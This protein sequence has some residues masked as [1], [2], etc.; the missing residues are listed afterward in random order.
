MRG[1]KKK[2][3]ESFYIK[4]SLNNFKRKLFESYYIMKKLLRIFCVAM[5]AWFGTAVAS[6]AVTPEQARSVAGAFLHSRGGVSAESLRLDKMAGTDANPYYY[7][8][9]STSGDGFVIVSAREPENPVLGY[10]LTGNFPVENVP[11]VLTPVLRSM[12]SSA[13]AADT[14]GQEMSVRRRQAARRAVGRSAGKLLTTAAWSQEAPFNN[15]IPSRRLVGCVGTAMATI[16]KYHSW[17]AKGSGSYDGVDFSTAYN[18]TAMRSDNYRNGYSQA[19]GEAVA[20]LMWHAAKSIGTQFGN[21]GSSAYEVRVPLAL[22]NYFGYDPGVSYKKRSEVK[23][24]EDWVALICN[25]IDENRP[26]LYCGQDMTVGHAFVCDG[27]DAQGYL[28]INWGWGG[29]ANG[30]FRHDDLT[31]TVSTTHNFGN[32]NTIIYN[33]KPGASKSFSKI[34]ITSDGN[35]PGIGSDLT[36]LASGDV[37]TVRVGNL[38]NLDYQDFKGRIAVA[39]FAADGTFKSLLS[40]VSNL[41]LPSMGNLFNGYVN[42]SNCALPSAV[43]VADG[44][45]V[46]IVT[47]V[48]SAS[49]WEPVAGELNTVN[50]LPASRAVADSFSITFPATVEGVSI[51]GAN[52]V[53][54][55]WDYTFRA[56][57]ANPAEDVVSVKANGIALTA[58]NNNTYRIANVCEPQVITLL[59]QK[60]SEVKDKRSYWVDEPGTLAAVIPEEVAATV[61]ELTLFGY[62]DSRDF[63]FIRTAMKL[64]RLDISGVK[65]MAYGTNQTNAVPREA[66]RGC[67]QLKEVILPTSVNRLNNGCFRQ[68]GITTITIPSGVKTYEYN[69][70]CGAS[71]LRDVWVGRESAEFINWCV[72]SGAKTALMTLHV[73]TQ[74]AVSNY[75]AAENWQA[76]ANIIVDPVPAVTEYS[77]AVQ[78]DEEVK[79]ESEQLPGKL[80]KGTAVSF[81]AEH[82]AD[83]DRRMEVYANTQ[84]LTADADGVYHA[85]VNTNTI[86]RFN[87]IDPTKVNDY[88]SPWKLTAANGSV[89]LFTDV[90]NV[91]PGREFTIRANALNVPEIA[92][93][94]YWAAA[95]TDSSGNIKEFISPV[96]LWGGQKGDGLKMNIKCCVSEASVREGNKIMLVTSASKKTWSLV[97]GATEDIIDALPAINNVCP[98]YN[99]NIPELTNAT[100]SGAVTS[101]VRGRDITLKVVPKTV[102][103]RINM[104]INGKQIVSEAATVNHTFVVMEDVDVDIDV[105]SPKSMQEVTYEV[106]GQA[107][108]LYKKVTQAS[109]RPKVI[110]TGK[111][112][113]TDL[114]LAFTQTFFQKNVKKVD[115]S[116]VEIVADGTYEA[117]TLPADLFYKPSALNQTVPAVEEIILP[118]GVTTIAAS[119]FKNCANIREITLPEKLM[120]CPVQT[121]TASGGKKF[122]YGLGD[123]LFSGCTSLQTI[124]I[125]GKPMEKDG[126]PVV[127]HHNP[128]NTQ[129]YNLGVPDASKVT[130]IVPEEYLPLYQTADDDTEYGNPWQAQGYNM[131]AEYP[132]YSLSFDPTRCVV[133]DAKFDTDLAA[134][135]LG[136]NVALEKIE[137]GST[138]YLVDPSLKCVVKDNG[139]VVTPGKDGAIPVTYHN[140][141]KNPEKSGSHEITVDYFYDLSFDYPAD[142]IKVATEAPVTDLAENTEVKFGVSV[143]TENAASFVAKVV[144]GEEV[145]TPGEDG[146]YS[147]TMRGNRNVVISAVP[148]NGATLNSGELMA[149][150]AAESAALTAVSLEGEMPAESL[151][152]VSVLFPR[153]ED[154]DLSD[155]SAANGEVEIPAGA[156]EGMNRLRTVSLPEVGEI[157]KNTFKDCPNLLTIDIPASV[158]AIGE[159]AFSGCSSLETVRL[160][161]VYSIGDGAFDGC[162]NLTAITL[163]AENSAETSRRAQRKASERVVNAD[164]AQEAFAGLNPNCVVILDE[165]VSTPSAKANYIHTS[166]GK[167]AEVQPDGTTVEREGRIYTA[168]SNIEFTSGWPLAVPHAFTAGDDVKVLLNVPATDAKWQS[169]IVPFAAEVAESEDVTILE[170]SK[171]DEEYEFEKTTSLAANSP[172]LVSNS[173]DLTIESVSGVRI[174]STPLQ[175]VAEGRHLALYGSYKSAAVPEGNYYVLGQTGE[176]FEAVDSENKQ[177]GAFGVYAEAAEG[178]NGVEIR[179]AGMPEESSSVENI[180]YEDGIRVAVENGR[181][182]VFA[183]ASAVVK[184]YNAEGMLLGSYRVE[185]GRNQLPA[186]PHGLYIIGGKKILL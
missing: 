149:L 87:L 44:D 50:E 16:M 163:L 166:V 7:V 123:R 65:I 128:Y 172:V 15:M 43:T 1:Q 89:G 175:A 158:S 125:P 174:E 84:K 39:L 49:P 19:E 186:L 3:F 156:F 8:F 73:P 5:A 52:S 105:Y 114:A 104:S 124:Y 64:T 13:K 135:F 183:S 110:V 170:P 20:T 9:N 79:F 167:L 63:E 176:A 56:V 109:V 59:V 138:L 100:V 143:E 106:S 18:W 97:K 111:V 60:A 136:N 131:L 29:A 41:T 85:T 169:V 182:V 81:R 2:L 46:K 34:H 55:G 71:S 139:E 95:L 142:I 173:K 112:R 155:V 144:C 70:F 76:I 93:Q 42:F 116:G 132:V 179:Y 151:A 150:D 152:A 28:H 10:S 90:V 27:Y 4:I 54:K 32:L 74:K 30:Y 48:D 21:S 148:Q 146:L 11:E 127:A 122:V 58:D 77:F 184:V 154:L 99:V 107:D 66:F 91:I 129:F 68:C 51:E 61:K 45:V 26:V 38:K 168:K 75:K 17:P 83:N 14:S 80:S 134:S 67:W 96:V 119:A 78:E 98:V 25:E 171:D 161:G 157:G 165:G 35:Q 118:A 62:M 160:T 40:A 92:S 115:L 101:A 141:A 153:L 108:E 185:A 57:P 102:S 86:I 162:D 33:I 82:V 137:L 94:F 31:P 12:E 36:N 181:I 121:T 23:R 177:L 88:D 69:V 145:L 126:K 103:D 113:P 130:V 53:I 140:P 133:K 147:V 120:S 180:T 72:F 22:S 117:N 24:D 47:S 6:S 159:G 164:I 37:F 178:K